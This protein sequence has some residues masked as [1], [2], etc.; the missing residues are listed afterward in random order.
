MAAILDFFKCLYLS[1]LKELQGWNSE[2]MLITNSTFHYY[3]EK[4]KGAE[5]PH[6]G[7]KGPP[8]LR[9]S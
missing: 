1:R 4:E 6:Q 3:W 5:G 2:L 9:R 7:P 8:A